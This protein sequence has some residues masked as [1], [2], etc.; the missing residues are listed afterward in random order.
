MWLGRSDTYQ[1]LAL[2]SGT[3]GARGSRSLRAFHHDCRLASVSGTRVL[4]R[5][6]DICLRRRLL[7]AF[8]Y[9]RFATM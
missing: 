1:P 5:R 7:K 6:Q 4:S 9:T 2:L 8:I 3:I